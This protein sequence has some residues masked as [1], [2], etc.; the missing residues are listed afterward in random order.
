[1][2]NT[3]ILC[4]YDQNTTTPSNISPILIL[5]KLILL[6]IMIHWPHISCF[7]LKMWLDEG[8]N[9]RWVNFNY[10]DSTPTKYSIMVELME[11]A[12]AL[13][14]HTNLYNLSGILYSPPTRA[15]FV[16]PLLT[17]LV[18]IVKPSWRSLPRITKKP[19][20]SYQMFFLQKS[21]LPFFPYQQAY[22]LTW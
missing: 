10:F 16:S 15:G 5:V 18:H 21:L 14:Y 11:R 22:S 12:T 9:N 8:N 17:G 2:I 4:F 7:L 19:W 20:P 1:M 3:H 6:I 13:N